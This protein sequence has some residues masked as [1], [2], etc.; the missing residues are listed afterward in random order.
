M[1]EPHGAKVC[2]FDWGLDPKLYLIPKLPKPWPTTTAQP[3]HKC[4]LARELCNRLELWVWPCLDVISG[5]A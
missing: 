4:Q 1:R 2:G 5:A 3:L